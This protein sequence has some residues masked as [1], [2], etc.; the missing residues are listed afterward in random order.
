VATSAVTAL[1]PADNILD[2]SARP[3]RYPCIILGEGDSQFADGDE[4]F[5]DRTH[6][7]LHVWLEEPGLTGAKA[8]VGALREALRHDPMTVENFQVVD[9]AM[10][11]RYLRDPSGVHSHAVIGFDAIMYRAT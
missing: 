4:T 3:E 11:A 1:V 9:L 10:N 8:I 2:R 6:A 5:H 7:D